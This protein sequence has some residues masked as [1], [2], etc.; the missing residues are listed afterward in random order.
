MNQAFKIAKIF[1]LSGAMIFVLLNTSNLAS[2]HDGG[3]LWRPGFPLVPCGGMEDLDN[4]Q[5]NACTR[6]DLFHLLKHIIDFL[7]VLVVPILGTLFLLIG[8]LYIMLGGA[9]PGLLNRGKAIFKDTLI[10]I[11][12][13]LL[14]WL[15]V[16]TLIRSLVDPSALNGD[17]NWYEFECRGSSSG[18][19]Q[20]NTGDGSFNVGDGGRS[21][22]AGGGSRW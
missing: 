12:I 21:G 22:G 10:G 3:G 14:S 18:G 11:L 16:N 7:I 5:P 20:I 17:L 8:G 15:I 2:A 4:I 19:I 9:N 6:C 1:V 13:I